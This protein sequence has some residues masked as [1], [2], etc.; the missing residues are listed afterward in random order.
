MIIC[1][2]VVLTFLFYIPVKCYKIIPVSFTTIYMVGFIL[3]TITACGCLHLAAI[4]RLK[5][6]NLIGS[7]L[8]GFHVYGMHKS[9]GGAHWKRKWRAQMSLPIKC[10]S[11]FAMSKNAVKIYM[12]VLSDN[13][14]NA[15]LLITF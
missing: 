9:G 12:R 8:N 2:K 15:I 11:H 7:V 1:S 13:I 4:I 6:K 3:G 14:T 10:C 5:S